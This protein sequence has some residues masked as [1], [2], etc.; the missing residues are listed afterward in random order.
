MIWYRPG[1]EESFVVRRALSSSIFR[2]V[3]QSSSSL[4]ILLVDLVNFWGLDSA[5]GL[6]VVFEGEK[7]VDRKASHFWLKV[8]ALFVAELLL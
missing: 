4:L 2:R 6:E 7:R 8:E 5:I 1:A 3:G